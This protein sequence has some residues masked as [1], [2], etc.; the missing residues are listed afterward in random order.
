[1]K[2]SIKIKMI[3]NGFL[4]IGLSIALAMVIAYVLIRNQG[5]VS[6]SEKVDQVVQIVSGRLNEIR[7]NLTSVTAQIG[8]HRDWGEKVGFIQQNKKEESFQSTVMEQRAE[9]AAFINQIAQAS[10][11]PEIVLYDSDGDWVCAV[12]MDAQRVHLSYP[13]DQ[14]GK[15]TMKAVIPRGETPGMEQ[16]EEGH[17]SAPVSTKH[18]LPLPQKQA[19]TLRARN[20]VLRMNAIAPIMSLG[21]N[22]D[23][24]EEEKVQTGLVF[25]SRPLDESFLQEMAIISNTDMNLFLG[26]ELSVGT[27]EGHSRLDAEGIASLDKGPGGAM[28]L[29]KGL[30]R[31]LVLPQGSYFEGIFPLSEEGEMKGTLSI[32]LSQDQVD[33]TVRGTLL[34]LVVIAAICIITSTLLAW[35]LGNAIIRPVR[36]V[37][38]SLKEIGEGGGDLTKV[39]EIKSKD[40]IGEL[41]VGFNKFIKKL[42]WI[43]TDIIAVAR[44][45]TRASEDLSKLSGKMSDEANSVY[46]KSD[47]V[48]ASADEM[49]FKMHSVSAI[50]EQA[51]A[52]SNLVAASIEE[53]DSTVNEIAKSSEKARSITDEAVSQTK[54]ATVRIGEL[55]KAA[56]EIG[57]VTE[58]IT[59]I[60]ELT[61]LLALNATI[62]AARAGEAG[63]G[64]AVV[65]DEIKGLARQTAEATEEIKRQIKGIQQATSLTVKDIEQVSVVINEVNESVSSIAS[66]VEEQSVTSR[67]IADNLSQTSQGIQ[68]VNNNVAHS[69]SVT[70]EMAQEISELNQNSDSM[71]NLSSEVNS[72]AIGLS[73]LAEQLKDRVSRFKV[74][75]K[76]TPKEIYD[77]VM[78]AAD[79]LERLGE[80]GLADIDNPDGGFVLKD[81]YC[82]VQDSHKLYLIAHPFAPTPSKGGAPQVMPFAPTLAEA[83][84][85]PKGQWAEYEWPKPG[86]EKPSRKIAFIIQI[87]GHPYQVGA[88]IWNDDFS[89][90]EL[91][92]VCEE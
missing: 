42:Q 80:K 62:E 2:I 39:L 5:K 47:T 66:A 19:T 20:G 73:R 18:K 43:V 59:E 77:L 79:H 58:A 69:S 81:S 91:R 48:S 33:K 35:L 63:K 65:A 11:I 37:V 68:E 24:K 13:L 51:S 29:K 45:L 56:L 74:E 71:S 86:E 64:F 78:R 72:S 8:N 4:S 67:E 85:D 27:L 17:M 16:W 23:L 75:E 28:A 1:M 36:R 89:V 26:S 38:S 60:S 46:S 61:N 87:E 82:F 57:K 34:A 88:G 44:S 21:W 76:A 14:S 7:G 3:A 54:R 40:E 83:A 50:M 41:A 70:A 10:G 32:L 15:K 22:P 30:Y 90:E 92:R 6:A 25:S 9:L 52:N 53:M 12:R 55:G 31:E 49:N 84:K